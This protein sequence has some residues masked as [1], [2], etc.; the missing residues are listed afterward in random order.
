[1]DAKKIV[2]VGFLIVGVI[3]FL[4][5]NEFV[6][7]LWTYWGTD[8]DL[9]VG[10]SL[11]TLIAA[12]IGLVIFLVLQNNSKAK[13]FCNEV[14]HELGKVTWADRS[15]SVKSSGVVIV[16]VAIAALILWAY[17]LLWKFVMGQFLGF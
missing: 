16:I 2:L 17:D 3:S 5:F 12:G 11:P 8:I 10:V 6:S 7:L 13:V 4:V 14:V 9:G 1:M 15:E